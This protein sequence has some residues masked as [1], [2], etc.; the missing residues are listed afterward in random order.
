MGESQ[1]LYIKAAKNGYEE[2]P[3][4]VRKKGKWNYLW[5][6]FPY[7]EK[8]LV[9]LGRKG[10][11]VELPFTMEELEEKDKGVRSDILYRLQV[12][13]GISY[14]AVEKRMEQMFDFEWVCDGK[15]LPLYLAEKILDEIGYMEKIP[16]KNMHI[17]I[18]S[19]DDT[20]TGFILKKLGAEY[21]YLTL[22][23]DGEEKYQEILQSLYEEYGLAVSFMDRQSLKMGSSDIS[24]DIFIDL[25]GKDNSYCRFFP[26]KARVV[27][28]LGEKDIRYYQ[29]K[30][31][32]IKLYNT[33]SFG[34]E[35]EIPA[36]LIQAVLGQESGWLMK[37][38]LVDYDEL[39]QNLNLKVL[40]VK[41]CFS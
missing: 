1:F 33:F 31:E 18:L 35:K 39:V 2:F 6:K 13:T 4:Y 12:E 40:V 10:K 8:E 36:P 28:L 7:R 11:L 34:K 21:N 23:A 5:R 15:Q 20:Y 16:K 27:D 14:L 25:T 30:R 26:E 3:W 22:V 24:G 41:S 29:G 38:A 17:V 37:G 19:G 9:V 32:D